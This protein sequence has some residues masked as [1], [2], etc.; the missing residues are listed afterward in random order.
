[1][2]DEADAACVPARPFVVGANQRSSC[3]A[4]RDRL[5]IDP[6]HLPEVLARLQQA[7]IG[8]AM[9][10]ATC[11]R[12]EVIG[13]AT[14]AEAV[15]TV[16][17]TTIAAGAGVAADEMTGQTYR[18]CDADAVRHV[19]RVAASLDSTVIGEP[20]IL[21]QIKGALAAARTAAMTGA[22]LEALS[23][24]ALAIGKRVRSDTGIGERPVTVTAAAVDLARSVH[25]ALKDRATLVL[26][27]GEMGDL[28]AEALRE[29]G[30][31]RL[32]F[33]HPRPE[34]A[35]A[36]ARQHEGHVASF[37]DL[38]PALA[39]AD[40]V[41]G[42][43]GARQHAVTFE[44]MRKAIKQRRQRPVLLIDTAVP[45][46]FDPKIDR[47]DAAFRYTF[48]D[49]ENVV[50]DGRASRQNEASAACVLVDEAVEAFVRE[51]AERAAVPLLAQLRG[52]FESV[53]EGALADAGADA[54]KA[55][56]LLINRLLHGPTR[57]LRRMAGECTQT[58]EDRAQ[59]ATLLRRLFHLDDNDDGMR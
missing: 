13:A 51:R 53:R 24:A 47:L 52:Y 22:E 29:A 31:R 41:L 45:G 30:L 58:S 46:D 28:I 39:D 57:T 25:G 23:Q 34:R 50:A 10:L 12:I 42:C 35:E 27:S 32:T 48:D 14:D 37:E 44:M 19:F 6:D 43:V 20:H 18:L 1:V 36:L 4:L 3:L 17:F 8:Q 15:A 2:T 9:L 33:S 56:R 21:A 11:D 55:T 7:G 26:G 54:D 5:F 59:L 38:A 49:L 40:I 16:A